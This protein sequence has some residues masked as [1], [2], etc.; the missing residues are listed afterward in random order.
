MPA[1]SHSLL[2]SIKTTDGAERAHFKPYRF[3]SAI[4]MACKDGILPQHLASH[5]KKA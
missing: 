5:P 3:F 1:I 4:I 2:F